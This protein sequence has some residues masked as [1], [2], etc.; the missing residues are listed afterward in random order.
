MTGGAIY[1]VIQFAGWIIDTE[2]ADPP[3]TR[4]QIF[5]QIGTATQV[6]FGGHATPGT[7]QNGTC[8]LLDVGD[9]TVAANQ[10]FWCRYN[11]RSDNNGKYQIMVDTSTTDI[12][13]QALAAEY[14]SD[15]GVVLD[16]TVGLATL[17]IA[18]VSVNEGDGMATV[19]VTVNEAV[20]GG[21]RVDAMT[22]D[23]G[24]ATADEDYTAV[25]KDTLTFNG[26]FANETQ[27]FTV[28]IIDD[29]IYDGG[30]SGATET[31]TISLTNLQDAARDERGY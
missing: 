31:V 9:G 7:P 20:S 28:T 26:T 13:G 25:S 12:I 23:G 11:T 2:L 1:S 17:S 14:T 29:A 22:T 19:T 24:S 6:Q 30:A 10:S 27:T 8:A 15:T 5:Y 4:P 18:N 21:F 16:V 3:D